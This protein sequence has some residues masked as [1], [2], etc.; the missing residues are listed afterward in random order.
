MPASCAVTL[1]PVMIFFSLHAVKRS[2]GVVMYLGGSAAAAVTAGAVTAAALLRQRARW[3]SKASYYRD[4]ATLTLAAATA[5][6]NAA[7]AAAA[8]ASFIST[9][10]LPLTACSMLSASYPTSSS[11]TITSKKERST[12]PSFSFY[13][14]N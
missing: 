14:L 2:G 4:A 12:R 7:V 9:K 10:Y 11:H 8:A 1:R 3:A 13:Y 5:A 6:C